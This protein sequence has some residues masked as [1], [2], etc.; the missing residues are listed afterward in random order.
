MKFM[1]L[2]CVAVTGA[3][4]TIPAFAHGGQ[5]RGPGDT[6]PPNPGGGGGRTPGPGGPRTPGPGG[7][8]T[9]TPG[10]PTTPGP[11]TP[12]PTGGQP[13]R[14]PVTGGPR[15]VDV[16]DDLSQWQFWWEF[17]KDP[18]LQLKARIRSGSTTTGSDDFV[19]G[20]GLKSE[21][22]DTLAPSEKDLVGTVIPALKQALQ[23]PDSNRDIVSSCMIALAKIGRDPTILPLF[24][25]FLADSDQEKRETAALAMGIAAL[26]EAAPDLIELAKDSPA[27]RKLA[28]RSGGIDFRSRSFACY[29]LGLIAHAT[30]DN[31][32]KQKIFDSMKEILESDRRSRRDVQV[33]AVNAIRLL[34]PDASK[35]EGKKLQKDAVD[36]MLGFLEVDE[37]FEQIRAH[38]FQA[39]ARLVGRNDEKGAIKA[40]F[41]KTV[42]SKKERH[43]MYQSAILALGEMAGPEDTAISK[44]IEDYME[45]GKDLQAKYFCGVA[46]GQI[47]GEQNKN[48]LRS[49]LVKKSTQSIVKPWIALGLALIDYAARQAD[50]SRD[51]DSTAGDILKQFNDTKSPIFA[52]G[53]AVALGVMR[54][55]DSGDTLLDRMIKYK[56]NDEAAGYIA[57]ALGL[58]GFQEAKEDINQLIEK[59]TRRPQL[60]TQCAIALGLLGDKDIGLKLIGRM[61]EQNT[62]A[63]FSALAQALG[64]IGDR[65]VITGLVE[66]LG[67]KQLQPLN[68]AFAAVALGLVGD[69]E[70]MPWNSKISVNINY[71]AN[72]ETLTGGGTGILD[73]L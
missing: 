17:N 42:T 40:R 38:A 14:G 30:T 43:W 23:D 36:Y 50:A 6:V 34:N 52:A 5:Y 57:V 22:V 51:I 8:T 16:G 12:A 29:G 37:V 24:K 33:A 28:D 56:N 71:R 47:G 1:R 35:E 31:A 58:M 46:L 72:V 70:L 41:L 68:R 62:V 60:L 18:F 27:G 25:K 54:D 11:Q 73:I 64:F 2:A 4:L 39:I 10:G 15:G 13:T 44:A 20:R 3:L 19:M 32:L 66:L 49:R 69:K 21:A 7:P 61:K 59:A 9:P 55:K 63:V 67:D 45:D 53:L 65:R 48:V 26:P